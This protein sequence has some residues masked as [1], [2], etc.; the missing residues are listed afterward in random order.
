MRKNKLKQ[1]IF[2]GLLLISILVISFIF[3]TYDIEQFTELEVTHRKK[4]GNPISNTDNLEFKSLD[5]DI[6]ELTKN[7]INEQ[8]R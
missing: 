5:D 4:D 3:G 1:I 2:F 8:A 6:N 7:I